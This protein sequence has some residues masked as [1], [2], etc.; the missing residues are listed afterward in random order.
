MSFGVFL[1][2]CTRNYTYTRTYARAKVNSSRREHAPAIPTQSD[3]TAVSGRGEAT[4]RD[5]TVRI[6]SRGSRN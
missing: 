6:R 4:Q 2:T 5:A 1:C 3:E